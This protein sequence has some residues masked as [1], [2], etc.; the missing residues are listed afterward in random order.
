MTTLQKEVN[1]FVHFIT[2]LAVSMGITFFA[3]GFIRHY[4]IIT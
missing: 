2:L 4:V 3:L 1:Y